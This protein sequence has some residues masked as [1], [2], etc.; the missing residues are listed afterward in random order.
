MIRSI[1]EGLSPGNADDIRASIIDNSIPMG[2]YGEFEDMLGLLVL[3][4]SDESSFLTGSVYMADGG[5]SAR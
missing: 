3:L 5:M 4:A 1:E 2:R